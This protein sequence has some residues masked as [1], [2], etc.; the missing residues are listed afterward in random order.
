MKHVTKR[1]YGALLQWGPV[2]VWAAVIFWFSS[3]AKGTLPASPNDTADY[4][5]KKTAHLGE[6]A[7]LALLVW[8]GFSQTLREREG[9]HPWVILALC[10]L[11]ACSDE[12][13][14]RFVLGR[15]PSARDVLI[16]IAGASLALWVVSI[17]LTQR[18]RN[19]LWFRHFPWLDRFLEGLL[20]L[21]LAPQDNPAK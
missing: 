17:V 4:I 16:D 3:R 12:F 7:I 13:H 15:E 14:Q 8:R 5:I 19:P 20:P 2:V 10:A 6:Y 1:R 9:W 21:R 18:R 11:Y